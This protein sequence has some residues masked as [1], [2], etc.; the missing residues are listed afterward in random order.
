MSLKEESLITY[1]CFYNYNSGSFMYILEAHLA[2]SCSPAHPHVPCHAHSPPIHTP[3][4]DPDPGMPRDPRPHR[5]PHHAAGPQTPP[6]LQVTDSLVI[7]VLE[8]L[9]FY[10][11]DG[12]RDTTEAGGGV[13][14][15]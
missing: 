14:K 10:N 3:L 11:T 1:F 12:A 7:T 5:R 9:G 2:K 15:R 8:P 4:R 6:L 13:G